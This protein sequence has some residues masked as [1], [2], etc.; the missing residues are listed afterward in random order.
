MEMLF[1][2]QKDGE[3]Y[4]SEHGP[5]YPVFIMAIPG[6]CC[7]NRED[8]KFSEDCCCCYKNVEVLHM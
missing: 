6:F 8:Y 3:M 1:I 4:N 2:T 5:A 7:T